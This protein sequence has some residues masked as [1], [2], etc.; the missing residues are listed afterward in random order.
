[1][2]PGTPTRSTV[3]PAKISLAVTSSGFPSFTTWK[4]ASMGICDPTPKLGVVLGEEAILKEESPRAEKAA[5]FSAPACGEEI[6][7]CDPVSYRHPS[8]QICRPFPSLPPCRP[9]RPPSLPRPVRRTCKN[10]L[11][12]WHT[13]AQRTVA[14]AKATFIPS[15]AASVEWAQLRDMSG[16]RRAP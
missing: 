7:K 13:A 14:D 4:V 3:L 15:P 6:R 8:R 10:A 2:A 11:V 5:L 16:E 9:F 12:G 1:M